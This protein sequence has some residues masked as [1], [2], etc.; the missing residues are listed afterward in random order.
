MPRCSSKQPEVPGVECSPGEGLPS[1]VGVKGGGECEKRGTRGGQHVLDRGP[2]Q[3][4]ESS[5]GRRDLS[6]VSEWLS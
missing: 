3:D 2:K 5:A 6:C 4:Q 1:A